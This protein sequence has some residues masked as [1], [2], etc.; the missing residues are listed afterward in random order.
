LKVKTRSA[1]L[2]ALHPKDTHMRSNRWRL[3]QQL[4]AW[5]Q[6]SLEPARVAA[7]VYRDPAEERFGWQGARRMRRSRMLDAR[8]QLR[9]MPRSTLARAGRDVPGQAG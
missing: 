8:R 7:P 3:F 6:L 5:M 9:L 2:T 4:A 1:H